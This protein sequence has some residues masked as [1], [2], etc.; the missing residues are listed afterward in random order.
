MTTAPPESFFARPFRSVVAP[1]SRAWLAAV[2]VALGYY[3]GAKLGFALTLRPVPVSTLWPPNTIMLAALV[4]A[5][6]SWWWFLLLAALPAHLAVELNSG[7]PTTLV[8]GWYLSNC[9]EAL[10]GAALI[11][12]LVKPPLRFDRTRD[13]F[14]FMFCG[15]LVATFLSSFI[16]TTFVTLAGV[17][18]Q[19]YWA[20]WRTRFLSNVLATL[21]LGPVIISWARGTLGEIQSAR[22]R[23]YLEAGALAGGLLAVCLFLF[24]SQAGGVDNSAVSLYAPL[25]FL[26]WAAVRFGPRGTTAS[27]LTVT[28]LAIWGAV[29]GHGPF[30]NNSPAANAVDVQSFLIVISVPLLVLAA[31]IGQREHAERF[32]RVNEERLNLALDA[33]EVGAWEW[34]AAD[35]RVTWSENS[36]QIFGDHVSEPTLQDFLSVV[37][38][39]DR[40]AFEAK[41]YRALHQ[42]TA[43]ESE[44][45]VVR[46]DSTTAW[47][48]GKG[49]A[50][51]NSNA[52]PIRM[53]GV[54]VDITE[55][56]AA[57]ELRRE[58]ASLRESEARLQELANAMPLIVWTATPDGRLDYFN[59]RWYELTGA[60]PESNPTDAVQMTHADDRQTL[61]DHWNLAV[62]TET[63]C[64]VEHRLY[65]AA[66]KEFRWHLLRALPIR[67][68]DGAVKRWYGSCTDIHDQKQVEQDLRGS[69]VDLESRVTE[70]TAE[71]SG[72]IVQLLKEI[73]DRVQ[74]EQKLRASEERFGKAF[75]SSPD[76]SVIMRQS[77]YRI[78]EVNEKWVQ[79]FGYTRDEAVGRTGHEIG[80][81]VNDEELSAR[82]VLVTEGVLQEY[83]MDVRTKSGKTLRTALT[84]SAAEVGGEPCYIVIIRDITERK[85]SEHMLQEQQREL[86]HLSRVAALGELSG[87]LA[88]ELNQPLAAIL[89]NARAAQ[90]MIK[91]DH[92]AGADLKEILEDIADDDR[93][94]G[95]VIARLRAFLK[96]TDIEPRALRLADIVAEVLRLVHSD[97]IQRRISV[98]SQVS[99]SLPRVMGD[100][101]QL[102]QVLLNLILNASDAM[103]HMAPHD[104]KL[105][106]RAVSNPD[107]GIELS[108]SDR[109]VGIGA[110][111]LENIF[112]PFVTTKESGL[113]L[114]LAIC[115]SIVS[116]HGGKLWA[117]NNADQGATFVLMLNPADASVKADGAVTISTPGEGV[118]STGTR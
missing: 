40:P 88:H 112:E 118:R 17:G 46:P 71:L 35:D 6:T 110:E 41:I 13:V 93:R 91:R 72:A 114:G 53:L 83:E 29:H 60:V 68:S 104:R 26:L 78:A 62:A 38:P 87:A 101:V 42:G 15:A 96:K 11:R 56:K 16:D 49:K 74:A 45:R 57:D 2:L 64:V 82:E 22:P 44:F 1:I 115:R 105:T 81:V 10:I 19:P 61:L 20:I 9:S 3:V 4:L 51:Y 111:R 52:R 54:N 86:A 27:L 12:A 107:G 28:L 92:P 66:T 108:V 63:P 98:D 99:R 30:L 32:S 43:Y 75:H 23:R 34:R 84:T 18:D 55:R 36:K 69:R 5:P 39:E 100:R 106:I 67:G 8:L 89:A 33:A 73:E 79:M 59:R 70:R 21:T 95:E 116:A 90:R 117:V 48:L 14:V 65:D 80:M 103:S 102:Q 37:H 25:P 50:L 77:D 76:A 24:N 31:E 97:L 85:R 47:V 113:G 7:F 58:E 94:A 109:G